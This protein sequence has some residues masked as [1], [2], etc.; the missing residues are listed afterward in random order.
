MTAMLASTG[1]LL[2][3]TSDIRL[4]C[5]HLVCWQASQPDNA[6]DQSPDNVLSP[7]FN[8]RK[9]VMFG[10]P[11]DDRHRSSKQCSTPG[12]CKRGPHCSCAGYA[13]PAQDMQKDTEAAVDCNGAAMNDMAVISRVGSSDPTGYALQQQQQAAAESAMPAA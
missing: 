4:L 12:H 1:T 9:T 5:G 8:P 13:A 10:S 7:G 2:L 11:L 3:L 6:H